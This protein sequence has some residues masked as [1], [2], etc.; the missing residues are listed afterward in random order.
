MKNSGMFGNKTVTLRVGRGGHTFTILEDLLC[1]S[2]YFRRILQPR[3]KAIEGDCPICQ[4]ALEGDK[5]VAFCHGPCGNNF[6]QECVNAW[7]WHTP[8]GASFNCPLCRQRFNPPQYVTVPLPAVDPNV[9]DIYSCWLYDSPHIRTPSKLTYLIKAYQLGVV[10]L[11]PAFSKDVLQ[12]IQKEC[13]DSHV[14]P[15]WHDV[16]TAYDITPG[17]SPLRE[18]MVHKYMQLENLD[19]ILPIWEKYPPAFQ[20]DF[21]KALMLSR[22]R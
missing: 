6:H 13:V 4:D 12:F 20:K 8:Q 11:E 9:F 21:A 17:T 1:I 18:F 14:H 16:M 10:F 7:Q 2:P 3:R 22:S 5:E 15:G 19:H